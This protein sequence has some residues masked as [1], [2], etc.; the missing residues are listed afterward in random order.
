MMFGKPCKNSSVKNILV[1]SLTNIGDVVLTCP[2]IDIL[3]RDFA[4]ANLSV[5]IGPKAASLFAGHPRITTIIYDKQRPLG[6]HIQWFLGLSRN[7]FDMIVDLRQSGLGLFLPCRWRT[8]LT[9]KPF[10]G[11]SRL[12]H[13][14]RLEEIYPQ[15]LLSGQRLAIIPKEVKVTWDI[16]N[17]VVIAPG[18]AD[19]AKRWDPAGFV[20][21]ADALAAQGHAIVFVGDTA[22][23]GLVEAIRGNMKKPSV[24]LAGKTDL[25]E[26]AFVLQRAKFAITHDSGTM[27]LAC[28]FD[29]PVVAV[30]GPTDVGKYGPWSSKAVVV[31]R[32]GKMS[33]ITMEDVLSAAAQVR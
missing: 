25:R 15:P 7:R 18:A 26:L 30:W 9:V 6:G 24:S 8:P 10:D 2:V 32:D 17:Y 5:I 21:V 22:D 14:R 28:Y 3:L 1:V 31:Y 13:L 29:V 11:H 4:S 12:K 23:A 19:S 33:S 27:H 20:K 16:S